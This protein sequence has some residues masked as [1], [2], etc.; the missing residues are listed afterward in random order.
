LADLSG[1]DVLQVLQEARVCRL[2]AERLS[3]MGAS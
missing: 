1:L 3:G 2:P